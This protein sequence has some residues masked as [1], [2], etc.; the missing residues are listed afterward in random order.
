MVLGQSTWKAMPAAL[1]FGIAVHAYTF[2]LFSGSALRALVSGIWAYIFRLVL[3]AIVLHH[4]FA[5]SFVLA[6][7]IV[8]LFMKSTSFDVVSSA[9]FAWMIAILESC[10]ILWRACSCDRL[11]FPNHRILRLTRPYSKYF[12][13]RSLYL[14]YSVVLHPHSSTIQQL[15]ILDMRTKPQDIEWE[16][17]TTQKPTPIH[18]RVSDVNS[19]HRSKRSL[20]DIDIMFKYCLFDTRTKP[21][22]VEWEFQTTQNPHRYTTEYRMWIHHTDPP[23][24]PCLGV[25]QGYP[26]DDPS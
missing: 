8:T 11:H 10:M 7:W 23:P 4:I 19:S 21:Q 3:S 13:P 18:H 1:F 24:P 16:S 14:F 12:K 5:D 25:Q 9:D 22:D 6:C 15:L 26:T 20:H 2:A 17:Q